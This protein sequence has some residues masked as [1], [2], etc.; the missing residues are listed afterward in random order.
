MKILTIYI[1]VSCAIEILSRVLYIASGTSNAY[2]VSQ[3]LN[4]VW[5]TII[6]KLFLIVSS[7]T[8]YLMSK[9]L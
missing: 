1:I 7:I 3:S 9:H 6:I 5:I 2:I 8:Y 4:E